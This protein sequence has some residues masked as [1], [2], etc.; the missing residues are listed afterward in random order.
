MLFRSVQYWMLFHG[1]Y[2]I[3]D[4]NWQPYSAFSNSNYY[5]WGGSHGCVNV[6]PSKMGYIYSNSYVGMRVIVY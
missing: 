5:R 3:H 4:A 1:G 2:G 6:H